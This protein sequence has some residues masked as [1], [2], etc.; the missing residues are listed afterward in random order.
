MCLIYPVDNYIPATGSR[1]RFLH[2]LVSRRERAPCREI[3][4]RKRSNG[5]RDN[6]IESVTHTSSRGSPY[7]PGVIAG[8]TRVSTA[9]RTLR[10]FRTRRR[11]A[12]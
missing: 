3:G 10:S 12:A 5:A 9:R 1:A 6:G 11:G 7:V 8:K 4:G 2:S